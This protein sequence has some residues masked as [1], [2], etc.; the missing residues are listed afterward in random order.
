MLLRDGARRRRRRKRARC[1]V[2]AG[3]THARTRLYAAARASVWYGQL[4]SC[5]A[6]TPWGGRVAHARR[7]APTTA[8]RSAHRRRRACG[9]P[10]GVARRSPCAR[11]GTW[12]RPPR[13]QRSERRAYKHGRWQRGHGRGVV[14]QPAGRHS[15]GFKWG[16]MT[17]W[18]VDKHEQ[19]AGGEGLAVRLHAARRGG[20]AAR[21][22]QRRACNA[23]HAGIQRGARSAWGEQMD[24]WASQGIARA[25]DG[26]HDGVRGWRCVGAGA[27]G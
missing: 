7:R 13:R 16:R 2:R 1:A 12:A 25:G 15:L 11:D 18:D 23:Q 26:L 20:R 10:H 3:R 27:L 5:T 8:P 17:H 14:R 22:A 6:C 24:G 19:R 4:N 9:Q 21:N